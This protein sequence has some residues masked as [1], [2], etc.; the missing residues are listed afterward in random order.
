ME[1]QYYSDN[2]YMCMTVLKGE[3]AIIDCFS[4]HETAVK[5]SPISDSGDVD[6]INPMLVS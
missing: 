3:C 6:T 2:S 4:V 5:L 1:Y